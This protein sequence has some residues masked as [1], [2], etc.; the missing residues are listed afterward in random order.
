MARRVI[1]GPFLFKYDSLLKDLPKDIPKI[2]LSV[3]AEHQVM[4]YN[5]SQ[6]E[7]LSPNSNLI[8]FWRKP[9]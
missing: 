8:H 2:Y 6:T 1:V 7:N 4:E 9:C 5:H 3:D